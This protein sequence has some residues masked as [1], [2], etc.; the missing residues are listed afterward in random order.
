[1]ELDLLNRGAARRVGDP[2]GL[3][4]AAEA[5]LADEAARKSMSEAA[6]S[7]RSD[8][9]GGVARTLEA[10]RREFATKE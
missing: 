2:P 3:A 9:G 5:L 7:W 4:A 1:I 6:A 10:I 8:N